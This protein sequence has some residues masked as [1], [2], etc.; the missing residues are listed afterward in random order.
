MTHFWQGLQSGQ[1]LTA[2]RIRGYSMILLGFCVIALAGWIA[3]SD[4]LIDR[5]GKPLGTDFSNV[6]A[7]GTYVLDG[8]PAAP[9]DRR[10]VHRSDGRGGSRGIQHRACVDRFHCFQIRSC[11]GI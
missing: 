3:L 10:T 11:T 6:Y 2:A 7:A 5:N 9:F 1:W 8:Q 4:G